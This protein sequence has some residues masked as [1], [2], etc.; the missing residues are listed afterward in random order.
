MRSHHTKAHGRTHGPSLLARKG[1]LAI[2]KAGGG[3]VEIGRHHFDAEAVSGLNFDD[4]GMLHL[5]VDLDEPLI[6]TVPEGVEGGRWT[7]EMKSGDDWELLFT[8]HSDIDAE[9]GDN[10]QVKGPLKF[11]VM[12]LQAKLLLRTRRDYDGD[13]IPPFHVEDDDE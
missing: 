3:M 8:F 9:S 10:V 5:T 2:V 1:L 6:Y 7:V 4:D 13:A 12:P 11:V